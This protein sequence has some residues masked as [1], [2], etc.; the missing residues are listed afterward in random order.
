VPR[1][2]IPERRTTLLD[3]A[4]RLVLERGF[5]RVSVQ[6]VATAAGVA[7]GAVYLE[8]SSKHELLDALL[9]RATA[10]LG[11]RVRT[12][13]E[14]SAGGLAEVYRAGTDELLADPLMRAAVLDDRAVLGRHTRQVGGDRYRERLG[15]LRDYLRALHDAGR[16]QP[17]VDPDA[18]ALALS[19]TTVGLLSAPALLGPLGDHELSSALDVVATLLARGLDAPAAPVATQDSP[20]PRLLDAL[21]HQVTDARPTDDKPT[22]DP[23][24]T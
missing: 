7:K 23:E 19:V 3:V 10:R 13:T 24:R 6:D 16:L 14:G 20:L 9:R 8:F 22:D 12:R 18:A 21:H 4:E 5:D 15:W 1:P 11:E 2:T 17:G